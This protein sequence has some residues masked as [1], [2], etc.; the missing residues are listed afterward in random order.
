MQQT[1]IGASKR[2]EFTMETTQYA[3][4][5]KNG[6]ETVVNREQLLERPSRMSAMQL[7]GER[8]YTHE[9]WVEGVGRK[10]EI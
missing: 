1:L 6:W 9:L 8:T 10:K 4:C 7:Y 5:S 2:L 3:N